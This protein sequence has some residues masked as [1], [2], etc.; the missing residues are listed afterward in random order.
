MS[1]PNRIGPRQLVLSG[2]AVFV[3]AAGG[4]SSVQLALHPHRALLAYILS[5]VAACGYA[6][7]LVLLASSTRSARLHRAA[8]AWCAAEFAAVLAVGTLTLAR[9]DLFPEPTVWSAFGAGYGLIPLLLP[10][11]AGWWLHA[12]PPTLPAKD[13]PAARSSTLRSSFA[14]RD[15]HSQHGA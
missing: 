5:A 9:P 3:V 15:R 1:E 11:A 6:V 12:H 2:Y 14:L 7:G 10:L 4:R 8:V 13:L